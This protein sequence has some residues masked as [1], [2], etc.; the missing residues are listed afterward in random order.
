MNLGIDPSLFT[1]KQI[2]NFFLKK[3]KITIIKENLIDKISKIQNEKKSLFY[4]IDKSIAGETHHKKISRVSS[5]LKRNNH[6]CQVNCKKFYF[7]KFFFVDY[8][9]LFMTYLQL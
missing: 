8:K 4:S 6:L 7:H 2:K 1:S 3:N 9:F 5:F